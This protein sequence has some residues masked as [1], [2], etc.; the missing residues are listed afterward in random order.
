MAKKIF[1]WDKKLNSENQIQSW[2][3]ELETIFSE[4][5][6]QD[7]FESGNLFPLK[8]VIEKLHSSMLIRQQILSKAE[9]QNSSKLRTYVKFK[10]LFSTP[11]YLT[12]HLTFI[13]RKFLAKI[14]LGC[15]EIMEETGRY[16]RPRLPA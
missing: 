2:H 6:M 9:C 1:I 7:I 8:Q 5:D 4:N 10:D 12:K 13:Q 3:S 11:T 16:A 15:L 14:C